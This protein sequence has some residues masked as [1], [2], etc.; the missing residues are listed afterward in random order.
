M[1]P[2]QFSTVDI[3]SLCRTRTFW[4]HVVNEPSWTMEYC[5]QKRTL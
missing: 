5:L 3:C 2:E 1:V 4:V